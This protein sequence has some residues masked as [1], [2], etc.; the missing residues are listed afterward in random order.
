MAKNQ[1]QR[2][3]WSQNGTSQPFA[4]GKNARAICDRSGFEYPMSDMVIEPGTNYLV[5]KSESDGRWNIID[6]PQNYPPTKLG[7]AIAIENPRVD[8]KFENFFNNSQGEI[9]QMSDPYND[10]FEMSD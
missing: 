10:N 6:H 2:G 4:K 9:L 8:R 3:R 7:D 1:T 5:H